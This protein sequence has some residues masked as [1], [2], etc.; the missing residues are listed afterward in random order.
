MQSFC[1]LARYGCLV[2]AAV[3]ESESSPLTGALVVQSPLWFHL[4][5]ITLH[6][7]PASP[8]SPALKALPDN[9]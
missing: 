2:K 3:D 6:R 5:Q 7:K 8:S 4:S 9:D 1:G